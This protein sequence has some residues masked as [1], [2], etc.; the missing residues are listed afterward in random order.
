MLSKNSSSPRPPRARLRLL[1]SAG[2]GLVVGLMAAGM[3]LG[4]AAIANA[5]CGPAQRGSQSGRDGGAP[6]LD[7]VVARLQQHYD[8]SRSF[9]ATFTEELSSPGGM[10]RTR[11][12]VVYFKKV[13]RMRWE[14]GAPTTETIVSDG[15]LVY[16]YEPD[17]NQVVEVAVSKA[18]KTNATAFLLG[19]GNIR[20][21]FDAALRANPPSDG[22]IHV[23]LT[24]KGG[25]DRMELG[26]DPRSYNIVNF[27]LTDQVG[28]V[29]KLKFS[30]IK[31]D[32]ALNDSLFAFT[33]PPGADIDTP[34]QQ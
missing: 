33:V 4:A 21:D 15:K 27:T 2:L 30:D 10:K 18:L 34:G 12:G 3:L 29:T 20:R 22:L 32:L 25:G 14:F 17:L 16:D 28:N 8:C 23:L 13:G 11:T 1:V 6:S 24:P 9:R 7:Q 26:L 31:M 19:L 5:A